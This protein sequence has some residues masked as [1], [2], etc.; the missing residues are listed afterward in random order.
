MFKSLW[1]KPTIALLAAFT[2]LWGAE[3][4]VIAPLGSYTS[5]ER[6]YWAFQPRAAVQPPVLSDPAAKKWIQTPIDAFILEGIRKAELKPAPPAT[7]E[8]LIRRATYD[9][10]GIPPTLEEQA[11]VI[12]DNS[13]EAI[14]RVVERLHPSATFRPIEI[15]ARRIWAVRPNC[16]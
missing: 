14:S 6:R 9:M 15:A 16:S 1:V 10:L 3:H 2:V 7:R 11:A 8:S 4:D 5:A 12:A 13:P